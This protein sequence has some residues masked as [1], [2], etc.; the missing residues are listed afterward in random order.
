M[1]QF[2]LI[3]CYQFSDQTQTGCITNIIGWFVIDIPFSQIKCSAS[4]AY[5]YI[6]SNHIKFIKLQL[7]ILLKILLPIIPI[8]KKGPNKSTKVE[9]EIEIFKLY[10]A[11]HLHFFLIAL[12][13]LS[14]LFLFFCVIIL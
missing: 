8:T 13:F 7:A 12:F 2:L 4:K 14:F 5:I 3:L 6:S 10:A 9:K 11:H 1:M